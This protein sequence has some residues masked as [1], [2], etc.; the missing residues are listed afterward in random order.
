M[1]KLV[2]QG[3]LLGGV[4]EPWGLRAAVGVGWLGWLVGG[5]LL[6]LSVRLTTSSGWQPEPLGGW[7]QNRNLLGGRV[8]VCVC[9][10]VCM[11][12]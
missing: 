11:C 4:P 7:L 9:V 5:G 1:A 3:G 12:M 8:C 10:C 6:L 2:V